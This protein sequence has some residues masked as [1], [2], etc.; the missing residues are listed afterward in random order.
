V[1]TWDVS[2]LEAASNGSITVTIDT[3]EMGA[4]DITNNASTEVLCISE[5]I[6]NNFEGEATPPAD[7]TP[8]E[9]A[10]PP[11][12]DITPPADETPSEDVTPP[13]DDATP[14][15]EDVVPNTQEAPALCDSNSENNADSAS[16]TLYIPPTVDVSIV[17][18]ADTAS[19]AV[20]NAVT[21]TLSY[22]N[23]GNSTAQ[24]VVITDVLPA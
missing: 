1:L 10:T 23:N 13:T 21:Y 18:T 17:K 5:S 2:N 20:G 14:P 22:A 7:E 3:D 16:T 8:S 12:D 6:Q 19:T 24:G 9:E 15:T 11:T 4:G